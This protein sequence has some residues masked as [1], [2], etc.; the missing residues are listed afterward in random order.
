MDKLGFFDTESI[1]VRK[2][3]ALIIAMKEEMEKLRA[4]VR[5]LYNE[6]KERKNNG[7]ES[8]Q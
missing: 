4:A 5:L 1:S 3:Y 2:L 8:E 7:E 6:I